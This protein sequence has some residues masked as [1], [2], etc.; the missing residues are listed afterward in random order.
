MTLVTSIVRGLV[1]DRRE[2]IPSC[3]ANLQISLETDVNGD[4]SIGCFA[5]G[6][7]S[8]TTQQKGWLDEA[9]RAGGELGEAVP[10]RRE[11]DK[12]LYMSLATVCK[13]NALDVVQ[14]VTRKRGFKSWCK[15]CKEYGSS[16]G[17]SLHEYS[18]LLE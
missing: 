12:A 13:N 15:L 3:L 8:S 7:V 4:T 14:T 10:E 9:S 16:T 6:V 5:T 1:V 17:T 11:T 18:N 2:W